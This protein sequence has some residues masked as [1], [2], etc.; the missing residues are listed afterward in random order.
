MFWPTTF[1]PWRAATRPV[2]AV[3]RPLKVLTAKSSDRCVEQL[4]TVSGYSGRS[5]GVVGAGVGIEV[6]Q[7]FLRG[8][9]GG[10]EK[11][12]V[13]VAQ[14]ADLQGQLGQCLQVALEDFAPGTL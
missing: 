14:L 8:T 6:G 12:L 3:F 7:R 9:G 1:K 5:V 13:H 2:Y 11:L 10:T 4:G